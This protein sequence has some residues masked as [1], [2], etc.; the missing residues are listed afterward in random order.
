MRQPRDRDTVGHLRPAADR[1]GDVH[2]VVAVLQA[3]HARKRETDLGVEP[4][5]DHPL[6]A[7]LLPRVGKSAVLERVPRPPF[8]YRGPWKLEANRSYGRSVDAERSA[9]RS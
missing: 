4:G 7:R 9:H 3:L 1:I 8:T 6:A 5:D 2:H